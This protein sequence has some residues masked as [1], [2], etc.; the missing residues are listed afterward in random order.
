MV[1]KQFDV[2]CMQKSTKL[3][4]VS[5]AHGLAWLMAHNGLIQPEM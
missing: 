5:V 1:L 3:L 2:V 4:K